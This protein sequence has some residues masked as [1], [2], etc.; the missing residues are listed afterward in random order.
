MARKQIKKAGKGSAGQNRKNSASFID[1]YLQKPGVETT[2]SGLAYR[3]VELTDS[4]QR[5]TD[6]DT[7]TIEQRLL[8]AD[9]TVIS[10]TYREGQSEVFKVEQAIDGLREA[11]Q[12][13]PLGSRMEVVVPPE[14]AW[15]K[16]GN[17]S[18][19][20]PNAVL[21]FDLRLLNIS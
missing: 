13:M 7:V 11:L 20:G 8:L 2:D 19:I 6:W 15:G 12:L 18:K 21:F 17:R 3:F 14:L 16:R 9:G 4:D 1:K 5:A 10:D